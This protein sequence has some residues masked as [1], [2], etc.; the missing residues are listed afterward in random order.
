MNVTLWLAFIAGLVSFLSPC[1]LPLV[2][3]YIGYMG[4][5]VAN[6]V[7]AQ[8]GGGLS[9]PVQPTFA[10]RVSTVTHGLT[11][12]AGFTFVFVALGLLTNFTLLR[13]IGGQNVTLVRE[14]IARVGGVLIV[15]FGLHFMGVIPSLLRR[16]LASQRWLASPAFSLSFALIAGAILLWAFVDWLV[17]VPVVLL[18]ILW[19]VLGSAFSNPARFWTRTAGT[20][21]NLLYADTRRQMVARGQQSYSSSAIMGVVFA[22]GWTPCIGPIYGSILTLASVGGEVGQAAVLMIAY[23]LGLGVPFLLAA[24]LLDSTQ[25]LIRRMQRHLHKVEMFAGAFLVVIGLLVATGRLQTLSQ[26]FASQFAD[27]STRL[28]TCVIGASQGEIPF[29]ELPAC[30]TAPPAGE[31]TGTTFADMLA[32]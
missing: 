7:A 8:T 17:G 9:L 12:V 25:A 20:L 28:D 21:Q 27:F 19:L 5:R 32:S 6:T 22:A 1:V 26:N 15:F 24:L 2:P 18:L 29:G 14:I 11:F 4:G 3:A 23:S 13:I 16:W 10:S 30:I 31:P